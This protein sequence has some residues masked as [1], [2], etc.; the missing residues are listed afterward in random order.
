M[1]V[2]V[3]TSKVP[4]AP[5]RRGDVGGDVRLSPPPASAASRPSRKTF[6]SRIEMKRRSGS[7]ASEKG[8]GLRNSREEHRDM[9]PLRK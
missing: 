6:Q 7:G 9:N 2:Y 4:G 3:D 5:G 8:S 1:L